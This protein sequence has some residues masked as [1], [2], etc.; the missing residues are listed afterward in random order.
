MQKPDS[1]DFTKLLGFEMVTRELEKELDFQNET[2][3]AKLGAKVGFPEPT[4]GG[5][6]A[7]AKGRDTLERRP[8]SIQMASASAGAL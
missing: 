4:D 5:P 1:I 8:S 2:V 6:V 3:G 7:A